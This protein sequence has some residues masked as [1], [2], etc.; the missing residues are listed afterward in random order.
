MLRRV[1]LVFLLLAGIAVFPCRADNI[2]HR[3]VRLFRVSPATAPVDLSRPEGKSRWDLTSAGRDEAFIRTL[4]ASEGRVTV[5][6]TGAASPKLPHL[7]SSESQEILFSYHPI[8]ETEPKR[9]LGIDEATAEHE[10]PSH[11]GAR[12]L[13]K[14]IRAPQSG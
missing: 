10:V 5:T 12:E 9:L 1:I 7:L 8:D 2:T 4:D 14:Q 13:G 3:K 11:S 6:E